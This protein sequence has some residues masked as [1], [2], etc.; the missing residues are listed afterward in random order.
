M[1]DDYRLKNKDFNKDESDR[2]KDQIT[3]IQQKVREA[4]IPVIIIF[5]G[6]SA[7][8][9]G[10]AINGLINNLDPRGFRVYTTRKPT[11]TEE[12]YPTMRRYWLEEPENGQIAIF[13]KSW[14]REVSNALFESKKAQSHLNNRY[15]EIL[16]F[17]NQEI[18]R[19]CL[20]IKIFLDISQETQQKRF[21]KLESNKTTQWRVTKANWIQNK[22]YKKYAQVFSTMMEKTSRPRAEWHVID[23]S[24][25]KTT[26]NQILDLVLQKIQ[27]AL[28]EKEKGV[29]IAALTPLLPQKI[30]TEPI[31]L[32]SS[33]N[34]NQMLLVDYKE[35]L[36]RLN[37]RLSYL[38]NELYQKKIPLVI[39]FEGWDAGG[40]GGA[41]R[42]LTHALD[43]RGYTVT[44]IQAPTPRE[45]SHQHLWRFYENL[46]KDGHIAVFDR[47]WYGRVM[48][49]R[50][51]GF[52]SESNWRRAFEEINHF[53]KL[54]TDHGA[55]VVKFWLQIDKEEQLERF[56]KRKN[57]PEKQYK[58]TDEDWRNREKWD[59]YENCVNEML[60]KTHTKNAPWIIIEANNKQF[61]RIKIMRSVINQ[62]EAKLKQA[63]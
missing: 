25:K 58:I 32:L 56:N 40:K 59:I 11:E 34:P 46:P 12:K 62:I 45:K 19:G 41:I 14:Y 9:K 30:K 1:F 57:T 7:S 18:A 22:N 55:I 8:G 49:E 43:P 51:E 27:Y 24:Q 38:H 21:K 60:Q 29:D 47:T 50:I 26:K 61:A 53:E 35:E 20:I 10:V 3:A 42:R 13:D 48:V 44:P 39:G 4:G 17:E 33:I 16:D 31:S 6:W 52:C 54:L 63:K 15:E 23:G 5:E 37:K 28:R 36:K 2:L